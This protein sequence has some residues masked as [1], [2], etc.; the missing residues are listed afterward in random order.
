MKR[1]YFGTDGVR[2]LYGGPVVNEAFAAR[3]GEAARRHLEGGRE[4]G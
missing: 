2:G 1:S 3:L 4:G